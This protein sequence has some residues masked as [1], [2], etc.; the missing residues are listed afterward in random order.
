MSYREG[1]PSIIAFSNQNSGL[2]RIE[3]S[4]NYK[5]D[6]YTLSE[7]LDQSVP[8]TY[9][10]GYHSYV[11]TDLQSSLHYYTIRGMKYTRLSLAWWQ[12]FVKN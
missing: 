9:F 5:Q 8:V 10:L 11:S 3:W 2:W 4:L 1:M 6:G 7:W 12:Y